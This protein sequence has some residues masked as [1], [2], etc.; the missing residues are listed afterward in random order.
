[1]VGLASG[2]QLGDLLWILA[3]QEKALLCTSQGL[4]AGFRWLFWDFWF[5]SA[6]QGLRLQELV[7]PHPPGCFI[8]QIC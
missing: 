8:R 4:H 1:M 6:I 2:L 5:E 3:H 7:F